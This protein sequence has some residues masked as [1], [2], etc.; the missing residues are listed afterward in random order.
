MSN[1]RDRAKDVMEG[2]REPSAVEHGYFHLQAKA[3]ERADMESASSPRPWRV[4]LKE[5]MRPVLDRS[6]HMGGHAAAVIN[7]GLSK[8]Q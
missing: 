6:R 4:F 5:M 8:A 2:K 3:F 7:V 1:A